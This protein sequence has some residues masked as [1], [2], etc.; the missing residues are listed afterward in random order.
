M[1]KTTFIKVRVT[2][3]QR[4]AYNKAASDL[5]IDVSVIIRDA[6]DSAVIKAAGVRALSGEH[7]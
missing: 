1:N 3:D 4:D 6:L 7:A 2:E 5:G